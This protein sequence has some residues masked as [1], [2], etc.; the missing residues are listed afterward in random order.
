MSGELDETLKRMQR[1]YHEEGSRQLHTVAQW[2]PRL[3]YIGVALA[4]AG[5]IISFYSGL[6]SDL[7]AL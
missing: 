6:Y 4:I 3:I 1:L 7:G 2:T 5:Q